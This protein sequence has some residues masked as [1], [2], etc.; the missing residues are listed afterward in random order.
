[1]VLIH[2][3]DILDGE[4]VLE[5]W[6]LLLVVHAE[7]WYKV[8]LLHS[9]LRIVIFQLLKILFLLFL[10]FLVWAPCAVVRG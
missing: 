1:M 8:K 9:I 10:L 7:H 5:E 2:L 4:W 6:L 3:V